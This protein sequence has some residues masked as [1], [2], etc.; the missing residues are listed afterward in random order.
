M[1]KTVIMLV[2][3]LFVSVT[4]A[5]KFK[6]EK[7]KISVL[8]GQKVVNLQ[9][10][11]SNLKLMKENLTEAEYIENRKKDLNEKTS[12]EGDRWEKKWNSA[13]EVFWQPKFEQLLAETA[14]S[15]TKIKFQEGA[16]DAKYTL[17]VDVIWLYPG[18]D[19]AMM[20]QS[21][22]VNTILKIVD[23]ADPTKVL[24]EVTSLEAPGD[25]WG[26]N[27]SNESRIGEGFAKT[28]K[29]FGKLISKELK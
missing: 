16:A 3:L 26:S 8:K 15:S 10:D 12:G 9:Y 20:K 28:A 5:Q 11:Y 4:F 6:D 22:K 2:L 25:Q 21:A 19:I 13:R 1:K 17:L 23:S 14:T 29:S 27:F 18:W 7:G 24:Y